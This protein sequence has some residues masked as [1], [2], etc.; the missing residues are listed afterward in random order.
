[1]Q[2]Y[3]IEIFLLYTEILHYFTLLFLFNYSNIIIWKQNP[4]YTVKQQIYGVHDTFR[5][6]MKKHKSEDD[7]ESDRDVSE[8]ERGTKTKNICQIL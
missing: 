6:L 4:F 7:E 1:M 5:K 3:C 2:K 8:F